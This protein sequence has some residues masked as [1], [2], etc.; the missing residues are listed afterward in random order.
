[1][2]IM[3]PPLGVAV[4]SAANVYYNLNRHEFVTAAIEVTK[5]RS[6]IIPLCRCNRRCEATDATQ[7]ANWPVIGYYCGLHSYQKPKVAPDGSLSFDQPQIEEH[8]RRRTSFVAPE[9]LVASELLTAPGL[10]R[11][12]PGAPS[13]ITALGIVN[14]LQERRS[15]TEGDARAYA[16]RMVKLDVLIPVGQGTNNNNKAAKGF[17]FSDK[18]ALY[19][20]KAAQPQR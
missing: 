2:V 11:D 13:S 9:A 12:R 18:Q 19:R 4:A 10:V 15:L 17:D 14:W 3:L 20:V 7:P 8:V 1:M 5:S 6:T 16:D